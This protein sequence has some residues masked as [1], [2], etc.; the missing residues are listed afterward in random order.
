MVCARQA[1]TEAFEPHAYWT[2]DADL[3]ADAGTGF[4]MRLSEVTP[5]HVGALHYRLRDRPVMANQAVSLLSRLFFTA[6]KTGE[7]PAGGNPCR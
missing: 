4:T 3:M 6:A 5:D 2:A 1:E 7:A